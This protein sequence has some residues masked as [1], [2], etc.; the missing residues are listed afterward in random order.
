MRRLLSLVL[1]LVFSLPL[2]LPALALAQGPG[3]NLPACCRRHGAHHCAM[4]MGASTTPALGTNLSALPQHCPAYS[5]L[6]T[7]L[8]HVDLAGPASPAD[9][10]EIVGR[11]TTGLR[12]AADSSATLN[13][14]HPKRG[15]PSQLL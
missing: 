13:F 12:S 11:T 6:V 7:S 2:I 14:S 9:F 4:S 1:L 10:A 8:R 3:A 5:A 15:P